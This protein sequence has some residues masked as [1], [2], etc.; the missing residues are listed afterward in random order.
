MFGD[1]RGNQ[2]LGRKVRVGLGQR[3]VSGAPAPSW[4]ARARRAREGALRPVWLRGAEE[5]GPP[6][7]LSWSPQPPRHR[8]RE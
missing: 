2:L 5:E 8:R 7:T 3:E 6:A 1:C 4:T